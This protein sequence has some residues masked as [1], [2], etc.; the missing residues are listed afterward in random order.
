MT[1]ETKKLFDALIALRDMCNRI[2]KKA[3]EELENDRDSVL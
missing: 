1:D 3:E 2:A